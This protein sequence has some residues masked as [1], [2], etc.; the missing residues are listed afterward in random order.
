MKKEIMERIKGYLEGISK[1]ISFYEVCYTQ[2]YEFSE[3][4]YE[5]DINECVSAFWA[6]SYLKT[7]EPKLLGL[8]KIDDWQSAVFNT[9]S[10][11]FFNFFNMRIYNVTCIDE[12][13]NE[14]PAEKNK[15]TNI[16]VSDFIKLLESYF[17]GIDIKAYKLLTEPNYEDEFTW[18][19][20]F[21][22]CNGIVYVLHFYQSG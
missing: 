4:K 11:W 5:T 15:E 21:F 8:V 16:V 14:M 6:N 13:G 3:Y 9:C 10:N 1:L 20:F 7:H 18:E 22:D 17:E 12:D 2:F 19:Q